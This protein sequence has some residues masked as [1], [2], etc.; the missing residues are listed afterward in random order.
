MVK[1][2]RIKTPSR[3]RITRYLCAFLLRREKSFNM[4]FGEQ[5]NS[6]GTRSI[7]VPLLPK[8]LFRGRRKLG[9]LQCDHIHPWSRGGLTTWENL[10]LLCRPCNLSKS[11]TP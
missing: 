9:I 11:D 4:G 3:D 7:T 2:E 1:M 5:R 10:Q 8:P 6:Y